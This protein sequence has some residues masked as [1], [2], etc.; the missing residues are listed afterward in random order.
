MMAAFAVTYTGSPVEGII[1]AIELMFMTDPPPALIIPGITRLDQEKLM[2][3][4]HGH[5]IVPVFRSDVFQLVPI[6][7]PCVVDKHTNCAQFTFDFANDS[8]NL[9]N[10]AKIAR[11]ESRLVCAAIRQLTDQLVSRIRGQIN[12]GHFR[13]L[14]SK[15]FHH[16]GAY[17]GGSACDQDG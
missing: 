17:S 6:V 10:I 7:V 15:M 3:K 14:L 5:S 13:A 12:K 4:V 2:A 1:H 16:R 8:S 9:R 11:P